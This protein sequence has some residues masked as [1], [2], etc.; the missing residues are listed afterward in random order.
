[1]KLRTTGKNT[2]QV[3]VL[4]ISK[5]GFWLMVDQNEYFLPFSAFPWFKNANISSI[6]N[7]TLP[8][9]HHLYWPDLD[10]DLEK[11]SIKS[12]EKYSLIYT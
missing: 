3:E 7:V 12:P 4:N 2:S 8:Q 5:Y 1:M 6:L 10:V 9:P 11:E